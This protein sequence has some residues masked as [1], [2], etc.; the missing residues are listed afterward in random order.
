[1]HA[2][3]EEASSPSGPGI[4]QTYGTLWTHSPLESWK[5]VNKCLP[6][7]AARSTPSQLIQGL[8]GIPGAQGCGSHTPLLP[9]TTLT[10]EPGITYLNFIPSL[11]SYCRENGHMQVIFFRESLPE[12]PALGRH[13]GLKDEKE[14][15]GCLTGWR[16]VFLRREGSIG[17]GGV[18]KQ[19]VSHD[20]G[21]ISPQ[22]G[23]KA[24]QACG[25]SPLRV[26]SLC[27]GGLMG[28][29]S[30]SGVASPPRRDST[31]ERRPD[32]G[33]GGRPE[34][35]PRA[36]ESWGA[37]HWAEGAGRLGVSRKR[38]PGGLRF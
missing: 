22:G 16:V 34:R 38:T 13:A 25:M 3:E 20:K 27:S 30:R 21:V 6:D 35:R 7:F 17:Q 1:M 2:G 24:Q 15:A 31:G 14:L 23:E 19:T 4:P 26:T 12:L 9:E 28:S 11:R 5:Q 29:K 18:R 33:Q 10:M 36:P 8:S 32:Q 37:G